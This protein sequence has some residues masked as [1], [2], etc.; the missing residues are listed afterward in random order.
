[1]RTIVD[2]PETSLQWLAGYCRQKDISR[3]EAIRS[4]VEEYRLKREESDMQ[5]RAEDERIIRETAG[6]WK[7]SSSWEGRDSVAYVR[8]IRDEWEDPWDEVR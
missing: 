8:A 6:A 5:K 4:A 2:I 3:A 1:M 7:H